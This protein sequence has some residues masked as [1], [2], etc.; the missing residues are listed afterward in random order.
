MKRVL[1]IFAAIAV[2]T[3]IFSVNAFAAESSTQ[4]ETST[5]LYQNTLSEVEIEELH[6]Q[7]VEQQIEEVML[8]DQ[9]IPSITPYGPPP[10]SSYD[11]VYGAEKLVDLNG[12]A[13]SQPSGGTQFPSGGGFYY[14]D[15][16]GP[17]VSLS[18]SWP[19]PYG[20][21]GISGNL[22][23]KANSGV[24]VNAPNKTNFFKLYITKT[25]KCKPYIIYKIDNRTGAKTEYY[26]GMT[27]V[28]YRTSATAKKV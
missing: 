2:L 3:S 8:R 23:N 21:F 7:Q 9:S 19:T 10:T 15:S 22:G 1:S 17:T 27:Q 26:K 20:S 13:G 24:F 4:M 18:Y 16:G 6:A 5:I 12:F 11:T 28:H 25:Y 14:S